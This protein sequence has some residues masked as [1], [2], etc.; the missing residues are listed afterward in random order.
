MINNK[1]YNIANNN[2]IQNPIKDL[3]VLDYIP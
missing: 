2:I 3:S 1:I